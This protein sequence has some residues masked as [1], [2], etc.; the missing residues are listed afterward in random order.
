[1]KLSTVKDL[2]KEFHIAVYGE[3]F[4]DKSF[5]SG[6]SVYLEDEEGSKYLDALGGIATNCLGYN[7]PEFNEALKEIIDG[8]VL[9]TSNLS[10]IPIQVEYAKNLSENLPMKQP[11]LFFCNSGAEAV[12]GAIKLASKNKGSVLISM[13]NSFHG[14]Y[15]D[16]LSATGQ[17]QY[18]KPFTKTLKQNVKFIPFNDENYLDSINDDV[19]GVL[20]EPIQGE[21]GIIIPDKEY[22]KILKEK[23]DDAQALLI[24]DEVQT[25]F[26]RTG[27][28]F[29]MKHYGVEPDIIAMGKGI[30]NGVP[31]GAFA[32]NEYA[33]L[34]E[35]G[36]HASTFGGNYLACTAANATLNIILK[37]TLGENSSKQGAYFLERLNE[38][39]NEQIRTVRG[40]GLMIGIEMDTP[41]NK[42]KIIQDALKKG[43]IVGGAGKNVVRIE[44]PLIFS[45]AD[46]DKAMDILS[47]V[48]DDL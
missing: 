4:F 1:M 21:G 10:Y 42:I 30:A 15:G 5:V 12:S 17:G 37:E 26:W 19:Y 47:E 9:H 20:V 23:C 39:D 38:L 43:L 35:P 31:M 8:G 40:K 41:E 6:D 25:G 28:S 32:V 36:E 2:D 27:E 3:R 46:V 33:D 13:E 22:F 48:Y 18:R 11:K 16:A 29:C 44:P 14:R 34:F 7:H 24:A 45:K